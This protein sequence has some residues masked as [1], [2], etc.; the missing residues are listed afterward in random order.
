MGTMAADAAALEMPAGDDAAVTILAPAPAASAKVA[1][2][3]VVQGPAVLMAPCACEVRQ[4]R[5]AAALPPHMH[6]GRGNS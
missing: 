6:V 4:T 2:F 3:P 1:L 5:A